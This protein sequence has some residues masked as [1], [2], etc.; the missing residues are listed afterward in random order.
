MKIQYEALTFRRK[1]IALLNHINEICD[2]YQAKG[3]Q[4]T[5][6]QVYY[7]CVSRGLCD[8]SGD[9]YKRIA[10]KIMAGRLAGILDWDIIEDRARYTRE[11]SHWSSPQE[12][13]S[14][15]AEQYRIDTRATQPRYIEAWCEKDALIG[16]LEQICSRL[17]VPCLSCRGFPSITLLHEAANR[18]RDKPNPIILYA[19]DHDPSG[20]KIPQ[21]IQ[22]RLTNTFGVDVE[23][24]RIGLT[25]EQIKEL[26]VPPY[27]AKDKDANYQEYVATT[28]LTQAWEL[29]ALPPDRLA[30]I[31]ENAINE[32]TD[33][34]ELQR[35]R[36]KENTDKRLFSRMLNF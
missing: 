4:I 10:D 23:L 34:Q 26:H 25:L 32:L 13:I 5:V 11:N 22:D 24:R 29:D 8:N 20:L 30:E 15:A 9:E 35:L 12:I 14:A 27:S 18:F 33:F 2:E 6:R 7:Q 28:G 3:L 17:D 21:T 19:G 31:F 36:E 1:T 16:I